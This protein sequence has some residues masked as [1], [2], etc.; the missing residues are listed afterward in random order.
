MM[1]SRREGE[2]YS[3]ATKALAAAAD[4]QS[5]GIARFPDAW[6]RYVLI[7]GV[8]PPKIAVARLNATV[9]LVKVL[10]GSKLEKAK[11]LGVRILTEAEFR[12]ML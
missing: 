2:R 1:R 11:Q 9:L 10:P 8:N 12:K 6:M 5:P 7:A 3:A 4:N